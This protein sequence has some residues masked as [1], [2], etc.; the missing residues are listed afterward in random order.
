VEKGFSQ[1]EGERQG[2]CAKEGEKE[3]QKE[4]QERGHGKALQ[5]T[6]KKETN[7]TAE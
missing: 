3:L 6:T 2:N 4:G 1:S 5:D 7:S